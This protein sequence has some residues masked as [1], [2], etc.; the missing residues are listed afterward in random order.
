M[1]E[2]IIDEA[3][4]DAKVHQ[5]L[6]AKKWIG[7]DEKKDYQKVSVSR[8]P[9]VM[10][11]LEKA[12]TRELF[13]ESIV[14]AN[15]PDSLLPFTNIYGKEYKV[16][17]IGQN[18]LRVFQ[19]HFFNYVHASNHLYRPKKDGKINALA[20]NPIRNGALVITLDHINLSLPLHEEFITSINTLN[21]NSKV[22]VV[23]FGNPLNFSYLDSTITAVQIF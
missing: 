9:L 20:F 23:N 19:N 7:L 15:N 2:G 1:E 13:E 5:L 10:S 21:Q 3:I 6:L 22:V 17:N 4:I 11:H 14:L 8:D 12:F 16:V 18:K